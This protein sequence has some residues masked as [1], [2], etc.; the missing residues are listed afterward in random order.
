M[1]TAELDAR[2]RAV[3]E[4]L[5]NGQQNEDSTFELKAEWADDVKCARR[6]AGHANAA[7]GETIIWVIGLDEKTATVT[8]PPH[9]ELATWWP[10][11]QKHFDDGFAPELLLSTV[12]TLD[13]GSV[14]ALAFKTE[15]APFVF[16]RDD[17]NYEVPYREGTRT[18]GARRRHLTRML[19][20]FI[21]A[22]VVEGMYCQIVHVAEDADSNPDMRLEWTVYAIPP[23][24]EQSSI[25]IHKSRVALTY[26]DGTSLVDPFAPSFDSGTVNIYGGT[27]LVDMARMVKAIGSFTLPTDRLRADPVHA[28]FSLAVTNVDLPVIVEAELRVHAVRKPR[29]WTNDDELARSR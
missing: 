6:L 3:A 16:K 2:V 18:G 28:R 22:P 5:T 25:I 4:R 21:K 24:R 26:A 7:R 14:V 17:G 20:P 23:P 13:A 8:S 19:V 15:G 12:V 1:R 9:N 27:A 29:A 10:K 11:V